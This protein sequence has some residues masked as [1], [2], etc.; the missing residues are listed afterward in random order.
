MVT[1]LGSPHADFVPFWT[2]M[3]KKK[4]FAG[5]IVDQYGEIIT[6]E[7]LGPPHYDAWEGSYTCFGTGATMLDIISVGKLG[8]YQKRI[9]SWAKQYPGCWAV[10][11]QADVRMRSERCLRIRERLEEAHELDVKENRRSS[12]N[13]DRPWDSVWAE[14]ADRETDWWHKHVEIPCLMVAAHIKK[15][16]HYVEG[17]ANIA[18]SPSTESHTYEPATG[19][20]PTTGGGHRGQKRAA[21]W[22]APSPHEAPQ[23]GAW[24][25]PVGKGAGAAPGG[26]KGGWE[27]YSEHDG[28]K[29]IKT[30]AGLRIC[31]FF[32]TGTCCGTAPG[33]RCGWDASFAHPCEICLRTGHGAHRCEKRP[34]GKGQGAARGGKGGW[35]NKGGGKAAGKGGKKQKRSKGWYQQ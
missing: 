22:I 29:W 26:G 25:Q 1:Q 9:R 5:T 33:N 15:V 35:S 16:G 30:K 18:H 2:T 17:D 32:Q 28:T 4:R 20:M 24:R 8:R 14:M 13:P 23:G 19:P 12:Y 3:I 21:A 6:V 34:A 10:I 27:D 11:Y 7:L 31:D